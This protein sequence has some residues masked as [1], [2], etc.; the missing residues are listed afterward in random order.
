MPVQR[1][2]SGL[3]RLMAA[4]ALVQLVALSLNVF[5]PD[6]QLKIGDTPLVDALALMYLFPA[7]LLPAMKAQL[8]GDRVIRIATRIGV[9]ALVSAAREQ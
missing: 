2:V 7:I 6:T 3:Q 5:N 8:G 4:V 1:L 9:T